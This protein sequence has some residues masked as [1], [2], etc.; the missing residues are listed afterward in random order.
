M[1]EVEID[2]YSVKTE[3]TDNM[4]SDLN[5]QFGFDILRRLEEHLVFTMNTI[6]YRKHKIEKI[7]SKIDGN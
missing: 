3:V 4:I 1:K 5:N 6:P 2:S 7:L